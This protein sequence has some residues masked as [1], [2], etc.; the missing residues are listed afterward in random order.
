M[1]LCTLLTTLIF[2]IDLTL[3][4]NITNTFPFFSLIDIN[5]WRQKNQNTWK[6]CS[7][8]CR[9]YH[10]SFTIFLNFFKCSFLSVHCRINHYSYFQAKK[11]ILASSETNGPISHVYYAFIK[12]LIS[13]LRRLAWCF[14]FKFT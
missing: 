9:R 3:I 4:Q 6:N 11:S 2:S 12:I 7:F 13:H 8:L 14:F 5:G 1:R 10:T